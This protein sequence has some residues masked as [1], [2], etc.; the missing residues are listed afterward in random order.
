MNVIK[1]FTKNIK[2]YTKIKKTSNTH[3]ISYH[4]ERYVIGKIIESFN[5]IEISSNNF[6]DVMKNNDYKLVS[7][8]KKDTDIVEYCPG[9]LDIN[10]DSKLLDVLKKNKTFVVH[11]PLGSQ[12]YPDIILGTYY[13]KKISLS[14]IECKQDKPTFNN[15]PPKNNPDCIYICGNKIYSGMVLI[16]NRYVKK[17]NNFKKDYKSLCINMSDNIIRFVPY[18]KIELKWSSDGPPLSYDNKSNNN[19]IR[20]CL[21][22]HK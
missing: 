16:N 22:K 3:N 17:I 13:D 11:Q 18:K 4:H 8:P 9:L 10:D 20:D 14:Y 6:K 19:Y 12:E 5:A 1:N 15:N 21:I 2:N 7:K